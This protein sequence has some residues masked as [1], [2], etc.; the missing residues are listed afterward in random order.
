MG[1]VGGGVG[2]GIRTGGF[3]I[4]PYGLAIHSVLTTKRY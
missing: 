3:E 4:R 1:G 2:I